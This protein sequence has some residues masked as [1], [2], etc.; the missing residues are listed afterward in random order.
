[1]LRKSKKNFVHTQKFFEIRSIYI[2][3]KPV[4]KQCLA[5]HLHLVRDRAAF[6][7]NLQRT[8]WELRRS[9]TQTRRAHL[10][11]RLRKPIRTI[12]ITTSK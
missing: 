2:L 9:A 7:D 8:R 1:M 11:S 4:I 6:S 12:Q 3:F 10:V 5:L